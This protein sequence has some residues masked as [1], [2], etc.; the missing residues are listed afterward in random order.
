M[1]RT[2][3][4]ITY[5]KHIFIAQHFPLADHIIILGEEGKIAEQGTWD[6]LRTEAGYISKV[7]LKEKGEGEDNARYRAKARATIQIPQEQPDTN[8]QDITRKPGDLSLYG[9]LSLYLIRILRVSD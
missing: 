6:G 1:I 5:A 4:L 3:H 7:I 8:M 2:S 9:K